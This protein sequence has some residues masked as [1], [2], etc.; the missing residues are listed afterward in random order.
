[1]NYFTLKQILQLFS[2]IDMS[3]DLKD[4]FSKILNFNNR[5]TFLYFYFLMLE[6]SKNHPDNF[7]QSELIF[8][9]VTAGF[10][11]SPAWNFWWQFLMAFS[12]SLSFTRDK[13]RVDKIGSRIFTSSIASAV[14]SKDNAFGSS[15]PVQLL[16]VVKRF[17]FGVFVSVF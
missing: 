3:G 14:V 6:I 15:L 2:Q 16:D 10:W 13:F 7:E 1:M 17:S 5:N 12:F 8:N 11:G 4:F 9:S